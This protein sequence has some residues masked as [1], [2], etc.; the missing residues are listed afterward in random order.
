MKKT[1]L[2]FFAVCSILLVSCGKENSTKIE[3]PET[4]EV[5]ASTEH[6]ISIRGIQAGR[7]VGVWVEN[8]NGELLSQTCL[9][10]EENEKGDYN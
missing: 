10:A 3:A 1:F 9:K 4:N 2:F 6:I 8:K 5:E 7:S